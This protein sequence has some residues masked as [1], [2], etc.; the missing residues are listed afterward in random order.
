MW[1]EVGIQLNLDIIILNEIRA[2]CHDDVRQCCTRMFDEWLKQ[3]TEASWI[4]VMSAC[5]RVKQNPESSLVSSP[6]QL[7]TK[8]HIE[9]LDQL[10]GNYV[11]SWKTCKQCLHLFMYH[12]FLSLFLYIK[13]VNTD[14]NTSFHIACHNLQFS[15]LGVLKEY[16]NCHC[17]QLNADGDAGLHILCGI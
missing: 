2:N 3:D 11:I 16:Y 4:T 1:R 12:S 8:D 13:A 14:G 10:A 5:T 15:C 6:N 17:N 7:H 9:A